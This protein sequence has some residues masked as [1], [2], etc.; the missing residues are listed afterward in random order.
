MQ[1]YEYQF[2][3]VQKALIHSKTSHSPLCFIQMCHLKYQIQPEN[4]YVNT[5]FYVIGQTVKSLFCCIT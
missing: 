1:I 4:A 2:L 5:L 3:I